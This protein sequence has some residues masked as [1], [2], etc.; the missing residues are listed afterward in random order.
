MDGYEIKKHIPSRGMREVPI[1]FRGHLS[2]FKVT[3]AET[4]L[5]FI[6]NNVSCRSYQITKICLAIQSL[7][8]HT[9]SLYKYVE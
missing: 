1:V 4:G 3:G 2:D 8:I 9:A 7:Y 5:D 6:L